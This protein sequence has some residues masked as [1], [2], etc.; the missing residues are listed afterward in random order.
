MNKN[1]NKNK[2]SSQLTKSNTREKILNS[3]GYDVSDFAVLDIPVRRESKTGRLVS[4]KQASK[5]TLNDPS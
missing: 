3:Y 4:V 1:K 2:I 5:R